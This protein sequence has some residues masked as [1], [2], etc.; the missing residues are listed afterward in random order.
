[1]TKL[2]RV[3][4]LAL[5]VAAAPGFAQ[6]TAPS[7]MIVGP[8]AKVNDINF[9]PDGRQIAVAS[10]DGS[11]RLF[12]TANGEA[13]LTVQLREGALY[14]AQ[15]SAD[16]TRILTKSSQHLYVYD[17]TNG[18]QLTQLKQFPVDR[19]TL[20]P[21]GTRFAYGTR[22]RA[23]ESLIIANVADA[24]PVATAKLDKTVVRLAFSPD[25]RSL[26]M[27][28][29]TLLGPNNTVQLVD[30]E[31]AA[32][33]H[34]LTYTGKS[35][36]NSIAYLPDGKSLLVTGAELR[37][38]FD[39]ATGKEKAALPRT[40]ANDVMGVDAVALVVRDGKAAF[41]ANGSYDGTIINLAENKPTHRISVDAEHIVTGLRISAD[42]ERLAA[43]VGERFVKIWPTPGAGKATLAALGG[44]LTTPLAPLRDAQNR[45]VIQGH[46]AAV[47]GLLYSASGKTVYTVAKDQTLRAFDASTGKE[48]FKVATP[49]VFSDLAP[50]GADG[51]LHGNG[52]IFNASTGAVRGELFKHQDLLAADGS[53]DGKSVTIVTDSFE[54]AVDTFDTATLK[55]VGKLKLRARPDKAAISAAAGLVAL[56]VEEEKS[57][58][59]LQI[60]TGKAVARL[61]DKEPRTLSFSPDGGTLAVA[62]T[63]E[64][65]LVNAATGEVRHTVKAR[66][67]D[68]LTWSP[69]GKVLAG[70][71]AIGKTLFLVTAS[72]GA[73]KE[74]EKLGDFDPVLAISPDGRTLA[75][76]RLDQVV[77]HPLNVAR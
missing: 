31:T 24:K 69:D 67:A 63:D 2:M 34:T 36:I 51:L 43:V 70:F 77:L 72:D 61:A 22:D 30:A 5:L 32:V 33:R 64:L 53:A 71:D 35:G 48:I 29:G 59:I 28:T 65:L 13:G 46:E 8:T 62:L 3:V 55:P 73:L 60:A 68:R 10:A 12:N 1:M 56:A 27:V 20:S 25:G 40:K 41:F 44:T 66:F 38:L 11:L 6:V 15:F 58:K 4:V 9:S 16:G 45:L 49:G 37:V 14:G 19:P 7:L 47:T 26:A 74:L 52:K 18:R 57:V 42:G 23:G 17:L 39:T 54:P 21:D 76:S 50:F 75:Y